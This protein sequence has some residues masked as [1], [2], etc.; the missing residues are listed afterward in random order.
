M[1]EQVTGYLT[2]NGAFYTNLDLAEYD[3]ASKLL[4]QKL[5]NGLITIVP[6]DFFKVLQ[7]YGDE[8]ARFITAHKTITT[9]NSGEVNDTDQERHPPQG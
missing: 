1:V 6:S 5:L 3:E 9:E 4:E 7:L 8:I 2:K